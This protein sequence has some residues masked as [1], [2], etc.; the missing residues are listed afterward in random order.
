VLQNNNPMAAAFLNIAERVAQQVAIC[1]A[2]ISNRKI[3]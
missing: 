1:N 2:G 3:N